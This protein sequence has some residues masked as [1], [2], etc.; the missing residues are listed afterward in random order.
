V[1]L[2]DVRGTGETRAGTS[3][4]RGS[5]RTSI[6]QTNLILGQPVLGAQ[7]RDLRAVIRH[8]QGYAYLDGKK[9]AV[10]GDSFAKPN[11]ADAKLAVPHDLDQPAISEPGGAHLALLAGLY[12]DVVAVYANGGLNPSSL[13]TSPYLYV[14]H[15][16]I[17][18]APLPV[19]DMVLPALQGA[20]PVL[21]NGPVDAQNRT[22][23]K[24]KTTAEAT[25]WMIEKLSGK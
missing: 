11:A 25:K 13:F 21:F 24:A 20:R 7:L 9:I 6:S 19:T 3:A 10:W 14:P 15:D 17:P 23:G 16:A 8:L 18:P 2:V 12:E 1:A 4:G 22:V 5:N